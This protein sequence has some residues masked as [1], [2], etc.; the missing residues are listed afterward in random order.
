MCVFTR[1]VVLTHTIKQIQI[2]AATLAVLIIV[3]IVYV[4]GAVRLCVC[5]CSS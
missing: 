2:F 5:E 1:S 3:V 4:V